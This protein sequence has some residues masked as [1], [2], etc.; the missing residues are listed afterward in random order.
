LSVA[1]NVCKENWPKVEEQLALGDDPT[2]SSVVK[3]STIVHSD[4]EALAPARYNHIYGD[5]DNQLS[6]SDC[7]DT[8]MGRMNLGSIDELND[9]ETGKY[10]K[11]MRDEIERVGQVIV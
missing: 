3:T 11:D 5:N 6:L 10:L 4:L 9:E 8:F 1:D 2:K 7:D